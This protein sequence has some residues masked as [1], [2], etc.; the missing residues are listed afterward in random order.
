MALTVKYYLKRRRLATWKEFF[1]EWATKVGKQALS[2][3]VKH[4]FTRKKG[5]QDIIVS[6][7]S[8]TGVT[9]AEKLLF[10]KYAR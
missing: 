5:I 9:D 10:G 6:R 3:F 1:D 7:L 2:S 8:P 4:G